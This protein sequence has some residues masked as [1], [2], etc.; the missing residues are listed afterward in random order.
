MFIFSKKEGT[1]LQLTTFY[2]GGYFAVTNHE[3]LCR[4]IDHD[5]GSD[6]VVWQIVQTPINAM[7]MGSNLCW[8][9]T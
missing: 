1:I 9:G 6:A 3:S 8:Q 5:S 4:H 2:L 7:P